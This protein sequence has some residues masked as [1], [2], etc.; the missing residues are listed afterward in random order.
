MLIEKAKGTFL[1][2]FST[3]NPGSYAI[4]VLSMD[5]MKHY[6]IWH[7][8]GGTYLVGKDTYSSL[9]DLIEDKKESLFLKFPCPKGESY[10]DS[11]FWVT[12]VVNEKEERTVVSLRKLCF[13]FIYKN[14]QLFTNLQQQ[15]PSDLIDEY[16]STI[17]D[18]FTSD[19]NGRKF[20]K[21]FFLGKVKQIV[22]LFFK[23][24]EN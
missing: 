12:S 23:K 20:W 11:N 3:T 4:S 2:R 14:R 22:F 16:F 18:S 8:P 19:E 10:S 15:L 7:Q 24:H 5:G 9:A 21:Q 13:R 6:K 17:A 1:I